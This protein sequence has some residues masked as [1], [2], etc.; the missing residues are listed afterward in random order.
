M[1]PQPP[2]ITAG[3]SLTMSEVGF[4][5]SGLVVGLLSLMPLSYGIIHYN[6]PRRKFRKLSK[7]FNETRDFFHEVSEEGLLPD[8]AFVTK[9]RERLD[10][11]YVEIEGYRA[12][13]RHIGTKHEEVK[14]IRAQIISTS[15]KERQRLSELRRKQGDR[16]VFSARKSSDFDAFR[17]LHQEKLD[18]ALPKRP[19]SIHN[20]LVLPRMVSVR[21]QPT[22]GA[23]TMCE[24]KA[25][26]DN[27]FLDR[28]DDFAVA[29]YPEAIPMRFS[30]PPISE[31]QAFLPIRAQ[32]PDSQSSK[33]T[34]I[35][36]SAR[37]ATAKHISTKLPI[38][39]TLPTETLTT[40]NPPEGSTSYL[41]TLQN[42]LLSAAQT[43]RWVRLREGN[44]SPASDE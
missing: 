30:V 32:S 33:P 23:D 19:S 10:N 12:E 13:T 41:E 3:S 27:L 29:A 14:D 34:L 42:Q 22:L 36:V 16:S 4:D 2:P 25:P 21:R 31:V 20:D 6:L 9:I 5:A 26:V 39:S 28:E 37:A 7:E 24:E 8:P 43:V 18:C 15:E 44:K 35:D 1:T 38:L 40:M 17:D 11:C